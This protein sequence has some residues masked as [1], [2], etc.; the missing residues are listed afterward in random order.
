MPLLSPTLISLLVCPSFNE[1]NVRKSWCRFNGAAS[2]KWIRA[3]DEQSP[4]NFDT[5]GEDELSPF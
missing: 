5:G 4:A 1:I 3:P 2:A